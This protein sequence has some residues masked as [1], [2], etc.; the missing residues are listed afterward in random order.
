MRSAIVKDFFREI[1]KS[2]SRWLSILFIVA[3]GVAFFSGI[4]ATSPDMKMTLDYYLD[5]TQYMDIRVLSTMGLTDE[6][7]RAIAAIDGV[8][9][10]EPSYTYDAYVV[11]G[12]EKHVLHFISQ[13]AMINQYDMVRGHDI[14]SAD[15][16]VV[17]RYLVDKFGFEVGDTITVTPPGEDELADHLARDS[18]KIVG[19]VTSSGYF[20][21]NRDTTDIGTGMTDAFVYLDRDVFASDYIS[22]ACI[23]VKDAAG[24]TAFS[25]S[26]DAVVAHVTDLLEEIKA[27]REQARYDGIMEEAESEIA[28]AQA[29]LDDARTE[30]ESELADAADKIADGEQEI[31]DGRQEL[32]D[33][34]QTYADE[35][36]RAEQQLADAED[37]IASGKQEIADG[38]KQL[39][40]GKK[41]LS[42]GKKQLAASEEEL[43]SGEKAY[44]EGLA[45]A[46]EGQTQLDAAKTELEEAQA[47]LDTQA[48]A[49]ADAR[50][51]ADVGKA[52][53]E[54]QQTELSENQEELSAQKEA[55]E[56]TL[57][58]LLQT[59]QTAED[60]IAALEQA[61]AGIEAQLAA[62]S[63][64]E[65][66]RAQ[67]KEQLAQVTAELEAARSGLAQVEAGITEAQT[68]LTQLTE[69]LTQVEA[70]LA[71]ITSQLEDPESEL[72]ASYAQIAA[73]E[74]A[75]KEGQAEIDAGMAEITEQQAVLDASF[76]E[77]EAAR[78]QLDEGQAQL[79]SGKKKI[80]ASEKKLKQSE[81]KLSNARKQIAEGEA[82]LEEGKQELADKKAEAE[83]EF[84]S[85]ESELTAAESE[86]ADAKIEYEDGK[87]EAEEK[88]AE[89][90]SELADAR[91]KLSDIKMPEWY[92]LDRGKTAG[93]V[94]YGQNADRIG[95]IGR[96]FPMIFFLVAAL[97]SLTTMTR[98]VE[99][100]RGEIGT[101]KALGYSQAA[102]AGKYVAYALSASVIGSVIG[103]IFGQKFIPWLIISTYMIIYPN[104]PVILTPLNPFYSL[105]SSG[106]AVLCVTGAAYAACRS[107]FH[108]T[109]AQLMRPQAPAAGK[110]I[111]LEYITPLW[112]RL[113][114]TGKVT[115]R[116]LFRYK[117]RFLMTIFGTGGC[118]ALVVFGFGLTDSIGGVVTRQ[119]DAISHCDMTVSLKSDLETEEIE[120]LTALLDQDTN[121]RE[122]TL[123]RQRLLEIDGGR[124]NYSA[125]LTVPG[126]PE[127]YDRYFS[128]ADR[129]TGE[130]YAITD[131][132]IVIT[133]KLA[134]LMQLEPGDSMTIKDGDVS[135]EFKISAVGENYLMSYVFMSPACYEKAF[136][137][138]PEYNAV[139][140]LA[141][142]TSEAAMDRLSEDIL[143][144]DAPSGTTTTAYTRSQFDTVLGSLDIITLV[145]V[146]AAAMLAFVVLYNLNNINIT[147]R[148]RELATI[149]VLG[150]YDHEVAAYVFREN[151]LL[152]VIGA[153]L[154][155]IFGK[156]LHA[157]IITTVETDVIMFVRHADP[158]S[159]LYAFLLTFMF[160]LAVN[161]MM[162]F[163]V[164]KIDMIES[165]KSVE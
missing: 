72:N 59:Q 100:G 39:N 71:Q 1:R 58:G 14:R 20:T 92:V 130:K 161:G 43:A 137:A 2:F 80:A 122:W 19:V 144:L 41:Q 18:F 164:R 136:N 127:E 22:A 120:E 50:E 155:L 55:A 154:G 78:A 29:E 26:Y 138:A 143:R 103:L 7:I 37:E 66:E 40:A 47:Q 8:Q 33:G 142:D 134:D 52:A 24:E 75:L 30:A 160:S 79:E 28:D 112:R 91:E 107:A 73:G 32:A 111:W 12:D 146:T 85:A 34:R 99:A 156:Y 68:G 104:L 13:P 108:E 69:G 27:D 25:E 97:I 94:D 135:A 89:G 60:G 10:V 132:A 48:K 81:K 148:R 109:P 54:A 163:S 57:A 96:V 150:F 15:E 105:L 124:A 87:R 147:E 88:I 36:A 131:D 162:F 74:A 128:L 140:I 133:E 152:T 5:H 16:C 93:Y 129:E 158:V 51:Q 21:T 165:L 113:S 121:V 95:A 149:K 35:V 115:L 76:E 4:R 123:L 63:L 110:K 6:D 56:S 83:S 11:D 38:Q 44:Q 117:K 118:T 62:D 90:E 46:Q 49:L 126:S 45:A 67:L 9:A 42:S 145:V 119:Y 106:A 84:A 159:Y 31:A 125:Y 114:F 151:I 77:L 86:L 153:A 101:L 157:F 116:N 64:P 61:Q 98:M 17:D 82:E 23:V 65:E 141:A 53:L 139:Q 102:I 3:L 70:G